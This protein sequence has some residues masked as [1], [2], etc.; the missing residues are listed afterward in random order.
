MFDY[1]SFIPPVSSM[2]EMPA[3]TIVNRIFPN[4]VPREKSSIPVKVIKYLCETN[5]K[6]FFAK[7]FDLLSFKPENT[8]TER[9]FETSNINSAIALSV[10]FLG[11]ETAKKVNNI[12]LKNDI[13]VMDFIKNGIKFSYKVVSLFNGIISSQIAEVEAFNALEVQEKKEYLFKI[14]R[15]FLDFFSHL[16][17]YIDKMQGNTMQQINDEAIKLF[18][19]L[20][21][22]FNYNVI[23]KLENEIRQ[24]SENL[25]EETSFIYY[26]SIAKPIDIKGD[27]QSIEHAFLLEQ[28]LINGQPNYRLYQS[29]IEYDDL[30]KTITE[31]AWDSYQLD[32]FLFNLY[33]AYCY[34]HPKDSILD[35]FGY[36]LE[37]DVPLL[38][39]ENN[40]LTGISIRYISE[41]FNPNDCL[42][43]L[44]LFCDLY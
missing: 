23:N 19:N 16:E 38:N 40:H 29:W 36:P 43:N 37:Y 28:F 17:P 25:S 44:K 35:C 15:G 9:D 4:G 27:E 11:V 33:L 21:F 18:K 22:S 41:K 42:E 20:D 32:S 7:A 13:Y 3:E 12:T 39:F 34:N 10:I 1:T 2:Q 26:V 5:L 30:R 31:K 24:N 6:G 14:E 8:T